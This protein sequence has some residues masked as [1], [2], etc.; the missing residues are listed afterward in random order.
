MSDLDLGAIEKRASAA[1]KGPWRSIHGDSYCAFPSVMRDKGPHF[2]IYDSNEDDGVNIWDAAR[3]PG[4]DADA[5]FIAHA[6]SDVPALVAACREK[7]ALIA[8]LE[9]ALRFSADY[10]KDTQSANDASVVGIPPLILDALKGAS[11]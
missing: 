5:D 8:E 3:F 7:D 10:I 2:I 9:K 11:K 6:R 4:L 1:T